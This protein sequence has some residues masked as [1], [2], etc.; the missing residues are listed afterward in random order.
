MGRAAATGEARTKDPYLPPMHRAGD[1]YIPTAPQ[2]VSAAGVEESTLADLVVKLAYSVARFT[3]EWIANELHLTVPLVGQLIEHLCLD[4]L[5]ETMVGNRYMITDRGREQASRLLE[6]CGY[7]GAAPVKLEAY[8]AMLRWQF[9]KTPQVTP[10]QVTSALSGLVLA[11]EAAKLAGLAVSSGRS[12]FVHG[13]SGNG[14]SSLGRQIH[15][16]RRCTP[17]YSRCDQ[18]RQHRRPAV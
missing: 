5:L 16:D 14:K 2:E 13:P 10:E 9:K 1:L 7:V 18:R 8:S 17:I 11:P 4:G 12:L 6:V 15:G 3:A